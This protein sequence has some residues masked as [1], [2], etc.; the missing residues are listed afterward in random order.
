MGLAR[1]GKPRVLVK[2][3]WI[4]TTDLRYWKRNRL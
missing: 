2:G 3:M 4:V 1:F